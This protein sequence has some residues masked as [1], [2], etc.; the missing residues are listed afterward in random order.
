MKAQQITRNE[1]TLK[2]FDYSVLE[3]NH[4]TGDDF[5]TVTFRGNSMTVDATDIDDMIEL[6]QD[7]R[8]RIL[9]V[10][11]ERG[12]DRRVQKELD[13]REHAQRAAASW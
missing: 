4:V 1:W 6:M 9:E 12:W 8:A 10:D 5:A 3:A 13:D 7:L 2:L 11:A